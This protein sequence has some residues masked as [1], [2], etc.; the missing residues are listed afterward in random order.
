VTWQ[1]QALASDGEN[2]FAAAFGG[3]LEGNLTNQELLL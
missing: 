2:F 1:L 3:E